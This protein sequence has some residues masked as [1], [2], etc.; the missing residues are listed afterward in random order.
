MKIIFTAL[1]VGFVFTLIAQH[2]P[3]KIHESNSAMRGPCEPS[4]C[5]NPD[6]PDVIVAGSVLDYVHYSKDG[7]ESWKTARLES[8]YGVWGDP[9]I[10]ADADGGFYFLHLSNPTGK[11]WMSD[12]ILDRIVCQYSKNGGKTWIHEGYMGFAHPKDQDKEWAAVDLKTNRMVC[13]WTQF[14]KYNSGDIGHRSN[15]LF[16]TSTDQGKTWTDATRINEKS[17]D[18]LDGDQTT[19]GAVPCFGP[20]GEI[21]V[22][23]AY[24]EN[25]FFD[26]SFDNGKTWMEKDVLVSDQPAGWAMDVE[27]FSRTNGMPVTACDV[28]EGPFKGAIYVCWGDRR[29]ASGDADI[30]FA[31]SMDKG[32]TWSEPIRVNDDDT[33]TEQFLPW[34]SVDPVTGYIYTVFYDRR[35]HQD[36]S[37]DVYVAYSKDA[38]TTWVNEKVNGDSFKASKRAFM[39]DYNN[40]SA[41]NGVV[42]PIWTE[43]H[44]GK[45]SVWTALMKLE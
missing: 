26:R 22:A 16:S 30:W 7:G 3:I 42:R 4:I 5:V 41:Y 24:D 19:E 35:N 43:L 28:S 25:I 40:I 8:S 23:W 33:Q 31:R 34:M 37:N 44:D 14:D 12:E 32:E 20:R 6:N 38:G 29:T 2:Q 36:T 45:L 21:Y 9:C 13:T 15:I 11:N 17:G 18:C 1:L 10:V 39:G 27:G